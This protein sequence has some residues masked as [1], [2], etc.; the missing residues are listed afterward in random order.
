MVR[1]L[2]AGFGVATM[3]A[4][5]GSITP[6]GQAILGV[7]HAA[8]APATAAVVLQT[9]PAKRVVPAKASHRTRPQA[10]RAVVARRPQAAAAPSGQSLNVSQLLPL[11]LQSQSLPSLLSQTMPAA[12]PLA[13]ILGGGSSLPDVL[14]QLTNPVP[15]PEPASAP[16]PVQAPNPV[17]P[18]QSQSAPGSGDQWVPENRH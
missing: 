11:L 13:G 15:T 14:Q 18:A 1:S 10:H 12:S 9:K 17:V 4:A 8:A 6:A 7:K 3:L 2:V 16:Q 5:A